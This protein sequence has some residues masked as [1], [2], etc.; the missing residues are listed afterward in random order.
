MELYQHSANH[1]ADAAIGAQLGKGI[2]G[3]LFDHLAC[4]GINGLIGAINVFADEEQPV[5]LALIDRACLPSGEK[6]RRTLQPA[7]SNSVNG[8]T[9]GAAGAFLHQRAIILEDGLHRTKVS[10]KL[11]R[12][13]RR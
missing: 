11:L 1:G 5:R 13:G 2:A 7:R 3:D 6:G 12:N 10:P 9:D 4:I 8:R